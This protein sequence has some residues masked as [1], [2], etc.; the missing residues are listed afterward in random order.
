VLFLVAFILF[1]G[2][3]G[4][5]C[6]SLLCLVRLSSPMSL[7]RLGSDM[8]AALHHCWRVMRPAEMLGWRGGCGVLAYLN[9]SA[10]YFCMLAICHLCISS[11]CN[12][13][14]GGY[15]VLFNLFSSVTCTAMRVSPA[16]AFS[17]VLY[18][19]RQ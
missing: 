9:I 6:Y 8:A 16:H 2:D 11:I 19:G 10:L 1:V 13:A 12:V 14:N 7:W 4:V 18:R 5:T 17:A 3:D 15:A